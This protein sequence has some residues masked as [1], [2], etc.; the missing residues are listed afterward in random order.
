MLYSN[1]VA[2]PSRNVLGVWDPSGSATSLELAE[3]GAA[4]PDGARLVAIG[5]NQV[6]STDDGRVLKVLNQIAPVNFVEAYYCPNGRSYVTVDRARSL[7]F[8]DAATDTPL[9]EDRKITGRMVQFLF[10]ANGERLVTVMVSQR[11]DV[12]DQFSQRGVFSSQ[13]VIR[14]WDPARGGQPVATI[15]GLYHRFGGRLSISPDGSRFA[16]GSLHETVRVYDTDSGSVLWDLEG[17]TQPTYGNVFSPDGRHLVTSGFDMLEDRI[18]NGEVKVWDI[19]TG[20]MVR[21]FPGPAL[22]T[23]ISPDGRLAFAADLAGY[24]RGKQVRSRYLVWDLA[25]GET[26]Y[27]LD[28]LPNGLTFTPDGKRFACLNKDTLEI[29]ETTTGMELLSLPLVRATGALAAFRS[30][31]YFSV[32]GRRLLLN[33]RF[34]STMKLAES[35]VVWFAPDPPAQ[36]AGDTGQGSQ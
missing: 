8:W 24:A 22:V 2:A 25:T 4:S 11:G 6:V 9:G 20:R 26:R 18:T 10:S 29:R 7:R 14:V 32:D 34:D 19:E 3:A 21:E 23:T 35:T 16:A 31:L 28:D 27:E 17:H 5:A 30:S 13:A 36:G 15:Q 1:G 12:D 33:G